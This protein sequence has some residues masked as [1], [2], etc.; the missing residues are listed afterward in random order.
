MSQGMWSWNYEEMVNLRP[1]LVIEW[2][3]GVQTVRSKLAPFGIPVIGYGPQ[4]NLTSFIYLLGLI[5][6]HTSNAVRL[7]NFINNVHHVL[8]EGLSKVSTRYKAYVIFDYE[9]SLWFTSG[10]LGGIHIGL[11]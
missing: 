5:T 8:S 4:D 6:D 1:D 9:Y 7:I 3:Y 11:P 2:S 10:P